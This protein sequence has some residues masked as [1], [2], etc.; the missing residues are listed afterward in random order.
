MAKESFL[1]YPEDWIVGT[2]YFTL[3]AKGAYFELL[4]LQFKQG[5]FTEKEALLIIRKP[6][7]WH[8]IK[9]KFKTDGEFYWNARL[10]IEVDKGRK[11]KTSRSK[12]GSKGGRPGKAREK[13]VKSYSKPSGF[14]ENSESIDYQLVIKKEAP[15]T[16]TPHNVTNLSETPAQFLKRVSPIRMEQM[17]MRSHLPHQEFEECLNQW[18]LSRIGAGWEFSDD[19]SKDMRQLEALWEKWLNSWTR[20]NKNRSLNGNVRQHNDGMSK[21][22][23]T[24]NSV[25]TL[26]DDFNEQSGKDKPALR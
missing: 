12:N 25:N 24:L 14:L 13:L 1:F 5:K 4:M 16:Q 7:I 15:K 9:D 17:E 3:E 19:Q 22:V 10:Q 11:F 21:T 2:M 6:R 26:I 20:N 8:E 18:S 23:T